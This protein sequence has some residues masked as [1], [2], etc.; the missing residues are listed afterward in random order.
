MRIS[1]PDLDKTSNLFIGAIF[2]CVVVISMFS[3]F[4]GTQAVMMMDYY[5]ISA[6]QYGTLTTLINLAGLAAGTVVIV[7][8]DSIN[9]IVVFCTTFALLMAGLFLFSL[10]IPFEFM[11]VL[12]FASGFVFTLTDVLTAA[13]V[14]EVFAKHKGT[15]YPRLCSFYD[16]GSITGPLFVTLLVVPK[17]SKTFTTP[18]F[19]LSCMGAIVFV[20]LVI[21]GKK[22][23]P[24]TP[25]AIRN[26][27]GKLKP[28][29]IEVFKKLNA[30]LILLAGCMIFMVYTGIVTWMPAY[31]N[32]EM[33][34][35]F[36]LSG[37]L[38]TLC[39]AASFSARMLSIGIYKK[40]TPK[41][42]TQLFGLIAAICIFAI[43]L[44]HNPIMAVVLI[45]IG[46][47]CL[48]IAISSI[49]LFLSDIFPD[50]PSMVA[51]ISLLMFN[52]GGT[53]TPIFMSKIA[54]ATSFGIAFIFISFIC[55]AGLL[56]LNA[57]KQTGNIHRQ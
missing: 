52:I 55:I 31:A 50:H 26:E 1:G 48:G 19:W 33:G 37:L 38:V 35:S 5:R 11:P 21:S 16:L 45:I 29:G 47:G 32:L 34:I 49:V 7:I 44:W 8:G 25:Y 51:V 20:L 40:L 14:L 13:T 15:L 12:G 36:E 30:W 28:K 53:I 46:G 18:F 9:K 27:K 3:S 22:I 2:S 4:F 42:S 23:M 57:V 24:Q 17:V 41:Q 43:G 10:A 54:Y 6:V 56:I 39:F